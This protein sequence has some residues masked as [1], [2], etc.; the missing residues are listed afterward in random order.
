MTLSAWLE[1]YPD[2]EILQPDSTFKDRY[3]GLK[4]LMKVLLRVT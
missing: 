2:A 4:N 1:Q 3:K